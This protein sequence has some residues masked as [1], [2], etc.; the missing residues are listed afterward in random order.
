[1]NKEAFILKEIIIQKLSR[2]EIV[3]SYT[4]I[5]NHKKEKCI[6][7]IINVP[8]EVVSRNHYNLWN[9]GL[10][11]HSMRKFDKNAYLYYDDNINIIEHISPQCMNFD[12]NMTLIVIN[13]FGSNSPFFPYVT[14]QKIKL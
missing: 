7:I 8:V 12:E 3:H 4:K 2:N 9:N 11:I 6:C 13:Y 10:K 14:D 1:M 5:R